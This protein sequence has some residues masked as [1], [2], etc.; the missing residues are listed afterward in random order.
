MIGGT[1]GTGVATV[2][3]LTQDGVLA[4]MSSPRPPYSTVTD[5]ATSTASEGR[6]VPFAGE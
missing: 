1:P 4:S 3:N 2:T 6:M 5:A